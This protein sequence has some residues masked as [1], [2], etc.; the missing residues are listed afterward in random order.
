M[1]R[2]SAGRVVRPR[3]ASSKLELLEPRRL[4]S[5]SRLVSVLN[6]P[7][8]HPRELRPDLV[9]PRTGISPPSRV[10]D[11]ADIVWVNRATTTT[12]GAGDTDSFGARFGTSA[13]LCRAVVDAVIASYER[14]IGSFNYSVPG[15]TY[16]LT[17][18]MNTSG[19][20][21]GA[22][23]S[24]STLLGGKPK[25]G[26]ITMGA[27][28]GS[29][30]P[31][32][33]NGW[34][35]DPTPFESSEFMGNITNEFSGDAQ[36]GSPAAGKGDFF[37]VVAAEMT[38]CMGMSSGSPVAWTNLTTNTGVA[39]TA[40]GGGIGFFYAFV[41]P[42]IKHLLTSNNGGPGGQDR[43]K[44]VHSA[45]PGGSN[46]PVSFNGD[47][48]WG[49]Q[50]QGNAV[51]E[52]GRRYLINNTF[53][54]M[55][56]D[57][58]QYDSVDPARW[59]TYYSTINS[60]TGVVTVRGGAGASADKVNISL[61]GSTLTVSVDVGTDVPGTGALAGNG[62]LPAF[63]SQYD[64]A[65]VSAISVQTGDGDDTI[66]ISSVDSGTSITVTAGNGN[67]VINI[68]DDADPNGLQ[69]TITIDAGNG[70]DTINVI[71]TPAANPVN[72][73]NSA[74]PDTVNVNTDGAEPAGALFN[75]TVTLAALN[76]GPDGVAT[77]AANGNRVL[78]TGA[79]S[80]SSTGVLDLSDNDLIL[81]YTGASPIGAIQDLIAAARSGGT[82]LG[83]GLTSSSAGANGSH[84]TTLGAIEAADFKALYGAG[85][86]FDG[87]AI[88][89]TAVLVKYTW[90]GDTDFNGAVNF[91]DYVRTDSGFNNQSTGW[92]NGDFDLNGVVNF[93]DYVLIDLAFNTQSGVL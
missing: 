10:S 60:T 39:D 82:W 54:L 61:A 74:G 73:L 90:Y 22:S 72:V 20:G 50:D 68:G 23:A 35:M 3:V 40:E 59:G 65:D 69:G 56:K 84:N 42:D 36:T 34:F 28:N 19:S 6:D 2:T 9:D 66:T 8:D 27:G 46:Q 76:V 48:Y 75:S 78:V 70:A 13:P 88:D 67:D 7:V 81:D 93:D 4:F 41:A 79:L 85:A 86:P 58:Y 80:I 45:G 14:M 18:S 1:S 77:I 30:D 64:V 26:S 57:A 87:V 92:L 25:G 47:V 5:S 43:L 21:F 83:G 49:A 51:Y 16:S 71:A 17:L 38:H 63:V 37:T 12:G 33:T 55:F 62:D 89:T 15:S 24:L 44:A 32:D 11:P 31:N 29:A 53:A 91:D 52:F